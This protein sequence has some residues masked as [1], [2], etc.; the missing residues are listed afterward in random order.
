MVRILGFAG[1][2]DHHVVPDAGIF[3]DDGVLDPAVHAHADARPAG[4]FVYSDG[5]QRLVIIAAEENDSIQFGAGTHEAADTDDAVGNASVI[6]NATVG[7]HRMLDVRAVD[8]GTR[9]E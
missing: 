9:Q 6:E 4:G 3:V 8:F 5:F 7:N 2:R 1:G